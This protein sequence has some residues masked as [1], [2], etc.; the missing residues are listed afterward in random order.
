MSGAG[1]AK[2]VDAIDTSTWSKRDSP[3]PSV[4]SLRHRIVLTVR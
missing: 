1:G 2:S 3:A 4:N